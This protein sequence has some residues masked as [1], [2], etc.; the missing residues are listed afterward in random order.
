MKRHYYV[1]DSVADLEKVESQLRE[2]GLEVPQLHVYSPDDKAAEVDAHEV[3]EVTDFTKRDV[4]RSGLIGVGFGA[5]GA[6][7]VLGSAYTFGW[8]QTSLGWMQPQF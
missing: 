5:A 8:A 1:C 6:A 3:H 4:I 2:A 7:V